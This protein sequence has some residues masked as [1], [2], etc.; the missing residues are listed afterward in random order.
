M[1]Y[2]FKA[3]TDFMAD[4]SA[5]KCFITDDY[6]PN[7][8]YVHE[9]PS[10]NCKLHR[11]PNIELKYVF[12]GTMCVTVGEHTIDAK[13]GDLIVVKANTYHGFVKG[14]SNVKYCTVVFNT[15]YISNFVTSPEPLNFVHLVQGDE[16]V[17]RI[18]KTIV[19]EYFERPIMYNQ[20]ADALFHELVIHLVRNYLKTPFEYSPVTLRGGIANAV[21]EFLAHNF[22]KKL[23][24]ET[25]ADT[26]GFNRH[27]MMRAFKKETGL[28]IAQQLKDIR[29]SRA[30][31]LMRNTQKPITE[32]AQLTGFE[33]LSHF[34]R[35]FKEELGET[36]ADYRKKY[37]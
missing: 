31:D 19:K 10:A 21:N 33:S 30:A 11:H 35:E 27:Y 22:N 3:H 6:I 2:R 15:D 12:E 32:V 37:R 28:T 18:F 34:S 17:D 29:L 1:N 24:I 8:V 14:K 20:N 13:P 4:G 26:M 16:V 5:V 25:I 23:T 7:C 9:G 36:P